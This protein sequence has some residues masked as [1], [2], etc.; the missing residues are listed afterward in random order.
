MESHIE[1]VEEFTHDKPRSVDAVPSLIVIEILSDGSAMLLL[2]IFTGC[3]RHYSFEIYT[4]NIENV[5]NVVVLH[6]TGHESL[7]PP[8]LTTLPE[9]VP[10]VECEGLA[11]ES[12]AHPLIPPMEHSVVIS[13]VLTMTLY[14]AHPGVDHIPL[15]TGQQW[16]G[17]GGVG[18]A[19]RIEDTA[20]DSL[21]YEV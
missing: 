21:A 12:H 14:G 3:R 20:R 11:K 6:T 5:S 8:A 18:P 2:D 9:K 17:E 1:N 15:I 19:V 7:H 10:N 13:G 16:Q 4:L